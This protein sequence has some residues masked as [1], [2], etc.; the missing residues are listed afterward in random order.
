MPVVGSELLWAVAIALLAACLAVDL[1]AHR[2]PTD[3]TLRSAAFWTAGWI[4]VAAIAAAAIW[5]VRGGDA[6]VQFAAGYTIEWSLS[7]DNV[8]VLVGLVAGLAVPPSLRYRVLFYGAAGAVALRL[9]FI[10]AGTALLADFAW[11]TYVFGGL[12][13]VLAVR[14]IRPAP[15]RAPEPGEPP[16]GGLLRRWLRVSILYDGGRLTT[17]VQGRRLATPLLLAALMVTV[18]DLVFATDSVPAVFAM[19]RDSFIAFTSNALAVMGLRSVYFVL[20]GL[21]ARLRYLRPALALLLLLVGARMIAAPFVA[22][23][24]ALSLLAT[25]VIPSTAVVASLLR[26][27]SGSRRGVP[28]V[29]LVEP[30]YPAVPVAA[31]DDRAGARSATR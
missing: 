30:R 17:V 6:G 9:A 15:E 11:L 2:R 18:T 7:V 10:L 28:S 29:R 14:M 3:V 23:P 26:S 5:L 21:V 27:R 19:T 4:G 12:L 16:A 25:V 1:W 8:L 13:I 24:V 31:T 20:E 22:V